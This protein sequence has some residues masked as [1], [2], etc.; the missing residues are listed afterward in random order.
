[1]KKLTLTI[2][3]I[4]LSLMTLNVQAAVQAAPTCTVGADGSSGCT[5]KIDRTPGTNMPLSFVNFKLNKNDTYI[6]CT[7]NFS[8]SKLKVDDSH[9]SPT[10]AFTTDSKI[11]T[12]NNGSIYGYL[13]T[14]TTSLTGQLTVSIGKQGHPI[15]PGGG[16]FIVTNCAGYIK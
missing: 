4:L 10:T 9:L 1:M 3:A 8:S 15:V 5:S 6:K 16:T 11:D 12:G 2:P 7:Y 14:K 13:S